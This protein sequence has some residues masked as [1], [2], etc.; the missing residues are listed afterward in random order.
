MSLNQ[1]TA[2]A[3]LVGMSIECAMKAATAEAGSCW[4][5]CRWCRKA[6][7]SSRSAAREQR[8]RSQGQKER[9]STDIIEVTEQAIQSDPGKEQ[10]PEANPPGVHQDDPDRPRQVRHI[11]H[12]ATLTSNDVSNEGQGNLAAARLCHTLS[13]WRHRK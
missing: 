10:H 3:M 2:Q 6:T 12:T 9:D 13:G 4:S 7:T 5:T 8:Q 11:F 1:T